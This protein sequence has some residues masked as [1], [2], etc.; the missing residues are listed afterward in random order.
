MLPPSS[1]KSSQK[2]ASSETFSGTGCSCEN[3]RD[4]RAF[5]ERLQT[6]DSTFTRR[7]CHRIKRRIAGMSHI[8]RDWK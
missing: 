8:W 2:R 1:E 6:F 5:A 3:E 7:E 4:G